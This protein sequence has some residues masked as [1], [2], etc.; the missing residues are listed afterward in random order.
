[1]SRLAERTE[2]CCKLSGLVTEAGEGWAL[3]DLR[4]YSA[5]VLD[6]FGPRRVMWGSDWPVC[7]LRTDYAGWL[8]AAKTLTAHLD[9]RDRDSIFGDTARG[10]YRIAS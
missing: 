10:F 7:R 4:P 2:A 6:C 9:E 3:E 5:H 1:M 8:D